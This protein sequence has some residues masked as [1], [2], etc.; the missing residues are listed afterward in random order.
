[1]QVWGGLLP[2]H[3]SAYVSW[4]VGSPFL[5]FSDFSARHQASYPD[6][7]TPER[8]VLVNNPDK[9]SFIAK[10]QSQQTNSGGDN[11]NRSRH[12]HEESGSSKIRRRAAQKQAD[13]SVLNEGISGN[14]TNLW[15]AMII[16]GIIFGIHSIYA[17]LTSWFLT[18]LYILHMSMYMC[19][20]WQRVSGKYQDHKY[21]KESFIEPDMYPSLGW[22]LFTEI[23]IF[24][25]RV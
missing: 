20:D 8:C 24:S 14:H 4:K 2:T 9:R 23:L 13:R 22:T 3:R 17:Y 16:D 19:K 12:R 11:N 15:A 6:R 21:F 5:Y 7:R 1:M 10:R 25:A 18:D